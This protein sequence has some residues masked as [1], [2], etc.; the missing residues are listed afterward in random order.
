MMIRGNHFF[1]CIFYPV[2]AAVLCDVDQF[3]QFI[4]KA[5]NGVY[6][7]CNIYFFMLRNFSALFCCEQLLKKFFARAYSGILNLD[8]LIRFEA[9]QVEKIPGRSEEHT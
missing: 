7:F 5:I 3:I 8:I 2:T 6:R 4:T 1:Y 9:R